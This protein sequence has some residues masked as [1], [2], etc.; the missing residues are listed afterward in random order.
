MVMSKV[1]FAASAVS[2]VKLGAVPKFTDEEAARS[3]AYDCAGGA[4]LTNPVGASDSMAMRIVMAKAHAITSADQ[5]GSLKS[6]KD[7]G[8]TVQEFDRHAAQ[9]CEKGDPAKKM[10]MDEEAPYVVKKNFHGKGTEVQEATDK[11][12]AALEKA[13]E[14]RQKYLG[15]QFARVTEEE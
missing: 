6:I 3:A 11:S 13:V 15:D 5:A 8:N 9:D 12:Y 2:A 1:L 10:D 4:D 14:V 7:I